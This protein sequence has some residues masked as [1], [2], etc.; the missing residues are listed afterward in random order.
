MTLLTPGTR[1]V[2]KSR[3][4][5]KSG[6]KVATIKEITVNP[7]TDKEAYSF[8]EDDSIVETRMCTAEPE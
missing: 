1:V 7:Y 8:I 3:R 2:K 4:P 5:F 6:D